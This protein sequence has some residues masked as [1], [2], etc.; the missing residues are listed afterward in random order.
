MKS[1][2]SGLF[3]VGRYLLID[4]SSLLQICSH[5][6][7]IYD[8]VLVEWCHHHGRITVFYHL[9]SK[10]HWFRQSPMGEKAVVDIQESIGWGCAYH[11]GEKNLNLHALKKISVTFSLISF[12]SQ[13]STVQHRDNF[14]AYDFSP[15][16]KWECLIM[17]L[18]SPALWDAARE[19]RFFLIHPEYSGSQAI[20]GWRA[21]GRAA[22]RAN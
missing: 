10:E 15:G 21:G 16:G 9:S 5:F 12:F 17:C 8:L 14:L 3:L 4:Q 22:D 11:L 18:A 6:L 19:T 7:F 13:G 20:W 2:G 1:S